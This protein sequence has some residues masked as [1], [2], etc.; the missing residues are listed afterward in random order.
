MDSFCE[1][2]FQVRVIDTD[3][4]GLCRPSSLMNFLQ[5]TATSHA[6]VLGIGRRDLIEQ[7]SA[8]WMVVRLKYTLF[9]PVYGDEMLRV[10]TWYRVP[11]GAFALRDFDLFV[12]E[13]HVGKAISTWVVADS[14]SHELLKADQILPSDGALSC[15]PYDE[16]LGKIKMPRELEPAGVRTIGYSETD[17]NGHAN[18][19]RYA[20]FACDAMHFERCAGCYLKEFQ[21][22]YSAECLAGQTVSMQQKQEET[23]F[24]VRGVDAAGKSHFD[25][26]MK[27]S[28]I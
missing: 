4:F 8:I 25:I 19:T 11:K 14:K 27:L 6:N 17:A 9:R 15:A 12:G 24:Y 2:T 26:R 10:R 3:L 13:E 7:S 18:N 23:T 5:E 20:D 21:I 16:K 1:E 28:D 22:T